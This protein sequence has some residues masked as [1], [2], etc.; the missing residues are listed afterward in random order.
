M[1]K[2]TDDK[3]LE[4]VI[5]NFQ[6]ETLYVS[7]TKSMRWKPSRQKAKQQILDHYKNYKSLAEVEKMIIEARIDELKKFD[8]VISNGQSRYDYFN[9]RIAKL[10]SNNGGK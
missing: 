5:N 9:D 7:R 1:N 3:W 8:T 10:Q 6:N 4:D 2:T